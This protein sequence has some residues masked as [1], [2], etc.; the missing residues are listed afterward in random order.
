MIVVLRGL[1]LVLISRDVRLKVIL[2]G[3]LAFLAVSAVI[4]MMAIME[5]ESILDSDSRSDAVFTIDQAAVEV[6]RLEATVAASQVP[7]SEVDADDVQTWFDIVAN[8]IQVLTRGQV[9]AF[10][11]A[12]PVLHD[13]AGQIIDSLEQARR[14]GEQPV[15]PEAAKQIL[16]ILVPANARFGRLTSL[17]HVRASE[18]AGDNLRI[19][20]QLQRLFS[21]LITALI[22]CCLTL[23]AVFLRHNRLLKRAHAEVRQLLENLQLTSDELADANEKVKKAM[24]AAQ[25]HN[26][27]LRARDMELHTQNARFDAAL[28]NMSQALCLVDAQSRL[29]ECNVRFLELFGVAR[30]AARPGASMPQVFQAVSEARRYDGRMIESIRLEQESLAVSGRSGKFF[31]EDAQ[32]RALAVSHQPMDDGGWVATYEDISERRRA[33]AQISFMAHHDA[34]TSLPNRLLFRERMETALARLTGPG[35]SLAVLCIDLDHFKDVNDTLGHPAGDALLRAVAG[36][37]RNCIRDC[38]VV[39]RLGGDEF[40]ILQISGD[41]PDAAES[42]AQRIVESLAETYDVDGHPAVVGASVGVALATDP[43]ASP[44]VLLKCADMALYRAKADGRGRHCFFQAEMD[45]ELQARKAIELDLRDALSRQQFDVFYQPQ[46]DLARGQVSGFEALLRWRHPQR[47]MVPPDQFIPIAEDLQLIGAIGEWVLHRACADATCWPPHV[48]IAV[49]LSPMQFYGGDLVET[50]REALASA[51][52]APSRL[53]L[54]ITES[55]LLE[56]DEHVLAALHRL[57]ALGVRIALDDFGT[58]YSS[59]SYL[60]SFPFDKIKVDQSFVREIGKRPDCLAIVRS[61][62]D[63]AQ[64][65]GM[66]TVAE[67]VETQEQLTAVREA[68]CTEVQG[69][70]LGRPAPR[71]ALPDAPGEFSELQEFMAA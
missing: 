32:G 57:R 7:G 40:A 51:G 15:G 33:E 71:A 69:Y 13:L 10:I 19:L 29:I 47:G 28:N 36:R 45:A 20:A 34:L 70:L 14:V 27:I 44:D 60:R 23:V 41:Q 53:E 38:D 4:A 49:N 5:R 22:V 56:H 68:G 54:E 24:A 35:D 12:D 8:R 62:A 46:F 55:A 61:I 1:G 21:A 6:A 59:L 48:H 50:V 58:G 42:L 63:L 2:S 31:Q 30:T 11:A 37:L 17:A 52:L 18:I 66:T 16:K 67:G 43:A 26:Q 3:V 65:L 64:Q 9:G 25:L 39:A